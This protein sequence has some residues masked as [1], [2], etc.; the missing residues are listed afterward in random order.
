MRWIGILV[1]FAVAA[2]LAGCAAPSNDAFEFHVAV[3]RLSNDVL[4]QFNGKQIL[5]VGGLLTGGGRRDPNAFVIDPVVNAD[6]GD[7]TATSEQI[8]EALAAAIQNASANYHVLPLD[9]KNV[10]VSR[11]VVT[12]A[13]KF[14]QN[15][16]LNRR[17]YRIY[18]SIVD[19]QDGTILANAAAW[20]S[21]KKLD[22]TPVALYRNSPMYLKDKVVMRQLTVAQ[23]QA[24]ADAGRGYVATL[25]AGSVTTE[26]S[27]ALSGGDYLRAVGLFEQSLNRPDGQTMKNYSGLYQA[28]Y[29]SN[30]KDKAAEAFA[31]L[32]ELGVANN[33]VTVKFLFAVGSTEF[34]SNADLVAQY[35][36]WLKQAARY[37]ASTGTCMTVVG[38]TS[39]TGTAD[40]NLR[41]SRERA[42]KI[43]RLLASLAP[44][45][46]RVNVDTL[47]RGFEENIIGTG[48]DDEQDAIDRR[49]EF[50]VRA[51]QNA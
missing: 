42:E 31:K 34:V 11:Y 44:P 46:G 17:L 39:H 24:G 28:Y 29:R 4:N 49:V 10:L 48:T 41:L 15:A 33:S 35:D 37:L 47:G 9:T 40:Y 26:A 21:D 25:D 27:T 6:T 22:D 36:I 5:S 45:S 43:Q 13:I 3:A 8:D 14:E 7:V 16:F 32:F 1:T 51:C 2:L 20:V 12:G 30:Q 23:P 38:H 50:R 18:A 19:I